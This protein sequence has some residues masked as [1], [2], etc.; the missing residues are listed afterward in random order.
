[1][2]RELETVQTALKERK[3]KRKKKGWRAGDDRPSDAHADWP[4]PEK[5]EKLVL[6]RSKLSM[7]YK[8][9]AF[10]PSLLILPRAEKS[11]KSET[12][13]GGKHRR[14]GYMQVTS[15]RRHGR[16]VQPADRL[17]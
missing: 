14:G 11:A 4:T 10:N 16:P 1:M 8:S 3:S 15:A 7:Y 13:E 2:R 17:T 5:A 6:L 12:S 9:G